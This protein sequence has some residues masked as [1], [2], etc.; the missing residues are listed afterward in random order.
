MPKHKLS[1]TACLG[2]KRSVAQFITVSQTNHKI[3]IYLATM[4]GPRTKIGHYWISF[5]HCQP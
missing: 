2:K 3:L 4:R 5:G 1:K